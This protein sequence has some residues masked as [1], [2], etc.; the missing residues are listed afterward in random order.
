MSQS[1]SKLYV[2][3]VF[4][5]KNNDVLICPEDEKEL[6]SYIGGI[7]KANEALRT[8]LNSILFT[9]VPKIRLISFIINYKDNKNHSIMQLFFLFLIQTSG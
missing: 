5:I 2:H 3:I 8:Y 6:Y 1:L 7:I 9:T 4:H